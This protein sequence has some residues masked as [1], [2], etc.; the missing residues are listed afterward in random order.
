MGREQLFAVHPPRAPLVPAID[1]AAPA[2]VEYRLF[3]L[4]LDQLALFFNDNNQIKTFGPIMKSLHVQR[5]RLPDL[6]GRHAQPLGLGRVDAQQI[7]RMNQI[8]PVL[9]RRDQPDLG[10]PL[11]QHALVHAVGAGKRLGREP[12]VVDHPRLLRV[13]RIAQ[14]DVQPARRH[15]EIGQNHLHPANAAIDHRRGLDRVLH[16]LEPHPEPGKP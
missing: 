10:P 8:E 9:A 12:L 16:R 3:D 15:V 13:R 5:E 7:E 2:V 1:A 6:I 4:H 14:P 11:A